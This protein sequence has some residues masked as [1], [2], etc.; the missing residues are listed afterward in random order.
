M[1]AA[2]ELV[3]TQGPDD[4]KPTVTECRGARE[5]ANEFVTCAIAP[6]RPGGS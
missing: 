4:A 5:K 6:T 1:G 3:V 2:L